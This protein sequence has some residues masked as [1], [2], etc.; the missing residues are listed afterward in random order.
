V[1]GLLSI[2]L[3][4]NGWDGTSD[5][6]TLM[7]ALVGA[8]FTED[9]TGNVDFAISATMAV[10]CSAVLFGL[11]MF[12]RLEWVRWVLA[13]LGGLT[14]LYYLYAIIWV[15]SNDAGKY[16]GMVLVCWVLWLAA[17]V[18]AVLPATGRAMRRR[19]VAP[20]MGYPQ[21]Y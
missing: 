10:A 15:L 1:L 18:V 11:V 5:N 7:L 12:T 21:A 2:M 4:V 17:T 20:P 8:A 19:P 16:V 14:T 9:A 6:G 3:A 13:V